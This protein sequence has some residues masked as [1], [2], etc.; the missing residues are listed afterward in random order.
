MVEIPISISPQQL[1]CIKSLQKTCRLALRSMGIKTRISS[2]TIKMNHLKS[3]ENDIFECTRTEFAWKAI[4]NIA[5]HIMPEHEQKVFK[6]LAFNQNQ[7][8][9]EKVPDT[10]LRR[11]IDHI[12]TIMKTIKKEKILT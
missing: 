1:K 3:R 9:L 2:H 7:T 10:V 4:N 12:V 11:V 8:I 5:K 6:L